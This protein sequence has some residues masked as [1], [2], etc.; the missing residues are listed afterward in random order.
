MIKN[1]PKADMHVHLEGTMTP[2][3]VEKIAARNNVRLPPGLL[4]G[5]RAH[6]H[7]DDD[8]TPQGALVSFLKAYDDATSV[9]KKPVDYADITYDY[10]KR[11]ADEG[12]I[13]AELIIS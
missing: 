6:F 12:C 8:G 7:W 1:L 5:D 2:E 13:Y 11:A 10:L 4:T 3:M 9:M